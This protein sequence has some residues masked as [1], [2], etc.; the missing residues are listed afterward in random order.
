MIPSVSSA[1]KLLPGLPGG[2]PRRRV[3]RANN[4]TDSRTLV[5]IHHAFYRLEQPGVRLVCVATFPANPPP[6]RGSR[7]P[8]PPLGLPPPLFSVPPSA[9]SSCHAGGLLGTWRPRTA[10]QQWGHHPSE[11]RP[12]PP[13]RSDGRR[14]ARHQPPR[15]P[16][17]WVELIFKRSP[18]TSPTHPQH[19]AIDICAT[20][21]CL[22]I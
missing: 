1:V 4:S 11:N 7:L 5:L 20:V 9:R 14:F 17:S 10:W 2:A 3:H 19:N 16:L 13:H 12:Q 15:S 22:N 6:S 18:N 21:C 8:H